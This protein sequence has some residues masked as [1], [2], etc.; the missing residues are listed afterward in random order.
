MTSECSLPAQKERAS[1]ATKQVLQTRGTNLRSCHGCMWLVMEMW[2]K[3]RAVPRPKAGGKK[4][5]DCSLHV[6]RLN[7]LAT[8]LTAE[9]R[10]VLHRGVPR[11]QVRRNREMM[12]Q[13]GGGI[14]MEGRSQP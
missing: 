14:N 10:E 3:E 12:R 8:R 1:G 11:V 6:Q 7:T 4:K 13:K 9:G 2:L 5:K